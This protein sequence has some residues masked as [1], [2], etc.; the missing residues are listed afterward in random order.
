MEVKKS[1][2]F[3]LPFQTQ[4]GTMDFSV[5]KNWMNREASCSETIQ[6]DS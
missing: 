6:D 3:S 5:K 4:Q 1:E 2:I